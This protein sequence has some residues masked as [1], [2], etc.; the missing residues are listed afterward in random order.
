MKT[1]W[2]GLLLLALTISACSASTPTEM[3]VIV[4]PTRS[5]AEGFPQTEADIPRVTVD[6]ALAALNSGAAVIVDVR[7]TQSFVAQHIAGALSIPLTR[8]EDN[9]K[10]VTLD[11]NQWIITYC[12]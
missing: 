8:I 4:A 6:E 3:A 1:R 5:L 9:P 10:S 2:I 7:A 11:K 12:T